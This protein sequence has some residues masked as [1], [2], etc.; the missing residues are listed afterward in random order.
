MGAH[1]RASELAHVPDHDQV[2][3]GD[4]VSWKFTSAE[5][6]AQGPD[7]DQVMGPDRVSWK[8]TSAEELFMA[9]KR[10]SN[11]QRAR[12]VVRA[13]HLQPTCC[14]LHFQY[15]NHHHESMV[16]SAKEQNIYVASATLKCCLLSRITWNISMPNEHMHELTRAHPFNSRHHSI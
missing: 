11:G 5:S 9:R 7:F 12:Q 14:F 1:R 6:L 4:R 10:D 16:G 8:G 2:I 15:I 3:G 13:K